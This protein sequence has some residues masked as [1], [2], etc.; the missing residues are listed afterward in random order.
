MPT[1]D[2][3]LSELRSLFEHEY[4]K[5]ESL[6][7][8]TRSLQIPTSQ[9][10]LD[11]EKQQ[12]YE[13]ENFIKDKLKYFFMFPPQ[14][15][16]HFSMLD[17]FNKVAKYE[18][19]IFIMT[20]FPEGESQ[21]DVE[22]TNVITAVSKAIRSCG[23]YPRTASES[24]YHSLLWDNVELYLLGCCKGVAIVEDHY[25]P[26]LN[27]NVAMEWGWMRGMGKDVLFLV[28]NDFAHPRAD[29]SGLTEHRFSWNNPE[30]DVEEAIKKWLKV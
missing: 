13:W 8:I 27:P 18:K 5:R 11:I 16:R 29:W 9:E 23:Y 22:L 10:V 14:H 30:T 15:S 7:D 2:I 3:I 24:D 6:K 17:E 1:L 26:E 19:S 28:E 12:T 21:S 4:R 20:K 25:K